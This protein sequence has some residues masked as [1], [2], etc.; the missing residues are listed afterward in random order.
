MNL[1]IFI[2]LFIWLLFGIVAVYG[3]YKWRLSQADNIDTYNRLDLSTDPVP[4]TIVTAYYEFPSKHSVA[5]YRAWFENFSFLNPKCPLVVYSTGP[6][7]QWIR[8]LC[9]KRTERTRIIDLPMEEF[10][11]YP[12]LPELQKQTALDP[13]QEVHTSLC[14]LIWNEKPHFVR[15]AIQADLFHTRYYCWMDCGIARDARLSTLMM[16]V[17]NPQ[18]L[19]YLENRVR[20][21]IAFLAID[22]SNLDRFRSRDTFQISRIN[23]A[24]HTLDAIGGTVFFGLKS[25]CEWFALQHL[26]LFRAYLQQNRFV[27]KDQNIYAN[28]VVNAP[29]RFELIQPFLMKTYIDPFQTNRWFYLINLFVGGDASAR[30]T[31]V[32]IFNGRLGNN[33]FQMAAV[34]G[35]ARRCRGL[36]A[37]TP[38]CKYAQTLFQRFLV[39]QSPPAQTLHV[40][41]SHKLD[42][43]LFNYT[44][45][46]V[47]AYEGCFQHYLYVEPFYEEFRALI[48]LPDVPEE[49]CMFLHLRFGDYLNEFNRPHHY[50]DLR[51]YFERCL[52]RIPSDIPFKVFSDEPVKAEA[53]IQ[54]H[55]AR[56]LGHRYRMVEADEIHS[57]ALMSQCTR[58][59][60]C[61]N[62]TFSWWGARLNPHPRKQIFIPRQFYPQ[63]SRYRYMDVSGMFHPSFTIVDPE[64]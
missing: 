8:A 14:Y 57:L 33:M 49:D 40:D 28:L 54:E 3:V 42:T 35:I 44:K 39:T 15:R 45:H 64:K 16:D 29:S 1:R 60:I 9:S 34:Y 62:S 46:S 52:E 6:A 24:P 41:D 47:T 37:L 48:N 13:E 2:W 12:H 27:G 53:Y 50:I 7:L 30:F 26:N 23:H 63:T 17:F 18:A 32:P 19:R 55:L 51:R 43:T 4:V 56:Q 58:G 61:S 20:D 38:N 21:R 31:H 25:S 22:K 59:G 10:E 36:C 5:E 11:L